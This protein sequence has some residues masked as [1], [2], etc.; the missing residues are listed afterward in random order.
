MTGMT[1][2]KVSPDV[3]DRLKEQAGAAGVTLGEYLAA[4]ARRGE[5]EARFRR[6]RSQI[7]ATSPELMASWTEE[8][9]EW[10]RAELRDGAAHG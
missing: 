8:T 7:E 1:T 6:F 4:L 2:I 10:E 9:A 5:R 3:R